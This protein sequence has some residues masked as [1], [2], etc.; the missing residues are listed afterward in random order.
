MRA[1]VRGL[2]VL[3]LGAPLLAQDTPAPRL[4]AIGD[5]HGNIAGFTA[6]LA[7]AG[8]TD[9]D[10]KWAGGTATFMQTGDFMDRD[11]EVRAVMDK[12]MALERE[13]KAAGG[14]ALA[15]LGNH[16]V[17]NL[18]GFTRD[19]T[20]AIFAKFAD[21]QSESRRDK[22]WDR[23]SK[24]SSAIRQRGEIPAA[25]YLQTKEQWMSAHPVG[26]LEYR[27]ALGPKG[28]YGMW[29]RGKPMVA[30]VGD[31]IFMHAGINPS[32]A[33]KD[34]DDLNDKVKA[35]IARVDKFTAQLLERKIVLPSFTLQEAMAATAGE[36]DTA[37]ALIKAANA[38]GKPIDPERVDLP[39]LNESVELLGL[40]EWTLLATEGPLWYRG[41]ALLPDAADGGPVAPLV[42]RYGARRFVIGHTP[43]DDRRIHTRFGGRVLAID[44]GMSPTYQGRA[45]ALE[46]AGD[47]LTAIYE[48]GRMPVEGAAATGAPDEARNHATV[49]RRPSSRLVD[50]R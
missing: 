36:L 24:M 18:I 46:I 42:E 25:V 2:I 50:G 14:K 37:N 27:E 16:E 29:L 3:V 44:T 10:G 28:P 45:S 21:A 9:A 7:K 43:T 49:W 38:G 33:P 13:A 35:E 4:V 17:M 40:D 34:L 6:I 11:D 23:Y 19:A 48:E 30:K 8:L 1:L 20:P 26:Y 31:S 15:L 12:L 41:L 5:I 39:F 32:R 22:E 47:T